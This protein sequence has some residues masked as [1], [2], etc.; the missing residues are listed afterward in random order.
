MAVLVLVVLLAMTAVMLAGWFF[1]RAA[2][3]GGWT[4][5]FWTFGTGAN[6]AITALIAIGEHPGVLWRRIMVA[7][8]MT[9]W[10][11]RL[12][13]YIAQRVA[14]SA[15]DVRYASL[16][17]EWGGTFQRNMFGLLISQAPLTALIGVAT[18]FAARQPDP[19]FRIW[20]GLALLVF[21]GAIVGET[22]A[23]RQMQAFKADPANAGKVCDRGLWSWSRHPNYFFEA[24]IWVAY[25]ILGINLDQPWSFATLIA[26]VMMFCIVR[27]GTGVPPLE[28]AMVKSKG[29]AYRRYQQEVSALFPRPRAA[30][31]NG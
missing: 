18:L 4:D 13:G 20:D 26:P 28:K 24:L 16:R 3:N 6:C 2:N 17:E 23:D 27:F 21:V 8:M 10:A 11:L 14:R 19:S 5:V 12:G 7:C 30:S 25:P 15:E 9:A 1:Q 29:D 31:P 22:I